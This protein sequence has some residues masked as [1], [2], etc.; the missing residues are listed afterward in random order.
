M[1]LRLF[2]AFPYW[3]GIIRLLAGRR[4]GGASSQTASWVA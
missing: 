4:G 1:N 3:N 2:A